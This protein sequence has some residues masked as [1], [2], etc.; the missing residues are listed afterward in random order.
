[1][2]APWK[3]VAHRGNSAHCPENSLEAFQSAATAGATWMEL[4]VR[5]SRDGVPVVAHDRDLRRTLG[6]PERVED[7]T[8]GRLQTFA[9]DA[10]WT[11]P[12]L[13]DAL[14][15]ARDCGMGVYVELKDQGPC[16]VEA[17]APVLE[18][19]ALVSSFH[20]PTLW[21]MRAARP[22]QPL[23]ALFE[24]RWRRPWNA[25]PLGHVQEIGISRALARTGRL[26][27]LVA[28]GWSV[29]VFTVNDA[30]EAEGFRARGAVGAFCDH[31]EGPP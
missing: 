12:T 16:V 27:Q 4:D 17:V 13:A 25:W 24:T 14:A 22:H 21:A 2:T 18:G 29:L 11:L 3:W 28:A 20:L 5:L 31:A 8:V 15:L 30:R 6:R 26:E 9:R 19:N 7:T 23:M 1:M 10:G